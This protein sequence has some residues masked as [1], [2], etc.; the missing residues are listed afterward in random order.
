MT[1]V[2]GSRKR[3]Y[4]GI[5]SAWWM[6][7]GVA[8]IISGV[9][10]AGRAWAL[11]TCPVFPSTISAC[12]VADQTGQ[13]YELGANLTSS[14]NCIKISAPNVLFE[15]NGFT[16]TG[17]PSTGIGVHV[18]STAPNA[19][20]GGGEPIEKFATG[21]QTDASNTFALEVITEFDTRGVVLNGPGAFGLEVIA[22]GSVKNGIVLTAAASG[23]FLDDVGAVS[24]GSNGIVL[25]GATNVSG[26]DF[27]SAT[28]TANGIVLNG[29]TGVNL[30]EVFSTEN[31]NYG[32]WLEGASVNTIEEA[33]LEANTVAGAYLG[34]HASGPS[35][36]ACT[37]SPS[38]GNTLVGIEVGSDCPT[39]AHPQAYGIAI[40]VGN[41]QNHVFDTST[42]TNCSTA[43]DTTD[44]GYD[45][46]GAACRGDF[47]YENTLTNKNHTSSLAHP[48]C[49][50]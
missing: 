27:E 49:M 29:T 42:D 23:S 35:A 5:G 24:N 38:N 2:N 11:P 39:P 17:S 45:G 7:A 28:N 48:L 33:E 18:L 44:D 37:I 9:F 40:D 21:F 46:N 3:A 32:L 1:T 8:T 12:C 22:E 15:M 19:I 30:F 50:D 4:E 41:G 13:A 26:L 20:F 43:G 14:G 31:A 10:V 34:C 47:W 25:N 16:I 36:S 6:A